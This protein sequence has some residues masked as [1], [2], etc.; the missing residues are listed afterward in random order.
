LAE[1]VAESLSRCCVCWWSNSRF[2]SP[3]LDRYRI[4]VSIA[5]RTTSCA[6]MIAGIHWDE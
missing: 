2:S 6:L 1:V 4:A 3:L 5:S